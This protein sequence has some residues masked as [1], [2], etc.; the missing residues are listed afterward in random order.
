MNNCW[1]MT[2][3]GVWLILRC[4]D[5]N[6]ER[7]ATNLVVISIGQE[8]RLWEDLSNTI[9]DEVGKRVYLSI[10]RYITCGQYSVLTEMCTCVC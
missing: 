1:G 2:E 3:L 5:L 9:V 6:L 4:S 10:L 8:V 7:L